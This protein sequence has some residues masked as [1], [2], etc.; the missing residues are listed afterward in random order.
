MRAGRGRAVVK[1]LYVCRT[2]VG[3]FYIAKEA[4]GRYHVMFDGVSLGGYPSPERA[5]DDVG[6]GHTFS[7]RG[8]HDTSTLGIP[9]DLS[10]WDRA[11]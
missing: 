4:E 6:G 2:R 10:S 5:A 7:V 11:S 1:T 9:R 8:G 3:P